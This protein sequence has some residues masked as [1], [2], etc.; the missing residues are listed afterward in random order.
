M[1]YNQLKAVNVGVAVWEQMEVLRI[2][3]TEVQNSR[4]PCAH[5][6]AGCDQRDG[7]ISMR[8]IAEELIQL[9]LAELQRLEAQ[10]EHKTKPKVGKAFE[11]KGEDETVLK[12]GPS[13]YVYKRP[14]RKPNIK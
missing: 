5:C 3:R 6:G 14:T 4:E 12:S 1:T 11:L 9:G 8:A 10:Y 7:R 13:V 2:R